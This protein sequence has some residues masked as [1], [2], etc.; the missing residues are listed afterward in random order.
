[1]Y[2]RARGFNKDT[3]AR[4]REISVQPYA[5]LNLLYLETKP[6]LTI[7]TVDE[8]PPED[9]NHICLD[10]EDAIDLAYAILEGV[11]IIKDDK[12]LILKKGE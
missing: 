12:R 1:M 4:D 9:L 2:Q 5:N 8:D 10:V 3:K 7:N 11:R 6:S